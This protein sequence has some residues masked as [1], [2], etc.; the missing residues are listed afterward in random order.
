MTTKY[1]I[2]DI[3]RLKINNKDS[4]TTKSDY[5]RVIGCYVFENGSIE[6]Q[7]IPLNTKFYQVKED[8]LICDYLNKEDQDDK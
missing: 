7:I 1:S 4:T 8:D 5:Y 6:Y 3:V 2:G